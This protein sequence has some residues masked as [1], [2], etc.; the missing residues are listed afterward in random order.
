MDLPYNQENVLEAVA[1]VNP[2][3]VFI[4]VAGAPVDL[5][6]VQACSPAIVQSWFNGTEG[7][8]AL[9]DI[10]LGKISPSGRLP[11]SYPIKL[12]DNPAYATGSFPQTDAPINQDVFVSLVQEDSKAEEMLKGATGRGTAL[13]S[14][15]MLVGYRWFDTKQKPVMYPF[16]YGLG[17]SEV[18]YTDFSLV[19]ETPEQKPYKDGDNIM[20]SI[21]LKNNGKFDQLDVPQVYVHRVDSKVEWPYKELKAFGKYKV[22]AGQSLNEGLIIPVEDLKY[23]NE[24]KH[25]WVLEPGKIELLLA[26][27]AGNVVAKLEVEIK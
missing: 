3:V 24:D 5:N 20:F 4:A 25:D 15:D 18:E 17:Y 2:N 13:Y 9:A 14:E 26:H 10:L 22:P 23:W 16:G 7:G 19:T 12:E 8:N 27:D 11:F 21:T 1:K 6:R